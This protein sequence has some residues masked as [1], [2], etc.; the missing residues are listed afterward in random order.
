MRTSKDIKISWSEPKI[1]RFQGPERSC[2]LIA[3][4]YENLVFI[5]S[6]RL[7]IRFIA[8]FILT[9]QTSGF[10]IEAVRKISL[11][12]KKSLL[13]ALDAE[14]V[15]LDGADEAVTVVVR[16]EN[17]IQHAAGLMNRLQV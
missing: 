11:A 1:E 4:S 13:N 14:S 16:R 6:P 3:S 12:S 15:I 2:G 8:D 17:A 9:F 10:S 5:L 7:P